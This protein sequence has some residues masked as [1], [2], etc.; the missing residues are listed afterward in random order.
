MQAQLYLVYTALCA[1]SSFAAG[2]NLLD[3]SDVAVGD[4]GNNTEAVHTKHQNPAVASTGSSDAVSSTN[5][6]QQQALKSDP[7]ASK[8]TFAVSVLLKRA[9]QKV[10]SHLWTVDDEGETQTG[11]EDRELLNKLKQ[12]TQ[13]SQASLGPDLPHTKS[14]SSKGTDPHSTPQNASAHLDLI[15]AANMSA[16]NAT[17]L[18]G[19]IKEAEE[20]GFEAAMVSDQTP[21]AGS[22]ESD[23]AAKTPAYVPLQTAANS[24]STSKLDADEPMTEDDD[25]MGLGSAVGLR[26]GRD[27]GSSIMLQ[28]G[29]ADTVGVAIDNK[30]S[31]SIT[32]DSIEAL[33]AQTEDEEGD[34][35]VGL[36]PPISV[37][38][39]SVS[40]TL[41]RASA[42]QLTAARCIL[43]PP[44]YGTHAET[45]CSASLPHV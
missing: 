25:Q 20:L 17:D 11:A 1:W 19:V 6:H 3:T 45:P 16:L 38:V 33:I 42:Q 41:S 37:S 21:T 15:T 40:H 4:Q 31:G 23:L 32:D 30:E 28:Q 13:V 36:L 44:A 2:H 5:S 35:L 18:Q 34:F 10:Y 24:N 9:Q 26:H 22:Q 29:G 39:T 7:T 12:P 8:D 27:E 43:Q 14:S